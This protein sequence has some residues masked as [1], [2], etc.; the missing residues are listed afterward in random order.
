MDLSNVTV[1]VNDISLVNGDVLLTSITPTFTMTVGGS[2]VNLS[3]SD[4]TITFYPG[5]SASGTPVS[6]KISAVGTYYASVTASGSNTA[7]TN[8]TTFKATATCAIVFSGD[9]SIDKIEDVTVGQAVTMPSAPVVVGKVFTGYYINGNEIGAQYIVNAS[10]AVDGVITIAAIYVSETGQYIDVVASGYYDD[11]EEMK[12][13]LDTLGVSHLGVSDRTAFVVF[14]AYGFTE[15]D[16]LTLELSGLVL[17]SDLSTAATIVKSIQYTAD[18]RYCIKWSDLS[19]DTKCFKDGTMLT[20]K[21]YKTVS[22]GTI[23]GDSTLLDTAYGYY[24]VHYFLNFVDGVVISNTE[25]AT[26]APNIDFLYNGKVVSLPTLPTT[27]KDG[28]TYYFVGWSLEQIGNIIIGAQYTVNSDDADSGTCKIVMYANWTEKN[29]DVYTVS[30]VDSNGNS[31]GSKLVSKGDSVALPL[32]PAVEGKTFAYWYDES[33]SNHTSVATYGYYTPSANITLKAYYDDNDPTTWTLN[34]TSDDITKGTVYATGTVSNG[35]FGTIIAVPGEGYKV[36]TY[37]APTNAVVVPMA[38]NVYL[39]Y[40]TGSEA[41]SVVF[42]FVA[43]PDSVDY[44]ISIR[45]YTDT[46]GQYGFKVKLES[47][48]GGYIAKTNAGTNPSEL[49]IKYVYRQIIP[50]TN[51]WTYY[52]SGV[53]SGV[54]DWTFDITQSVTSYEGAQTIEAGKYLYT[55]YAVFKYYNGSEIEYAISETILAIDIPVSS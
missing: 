30:F 45:N 6:D 48:D 34:A 5:D 4:Y 25:M 39:V 27:T 49:S 32:A 33:D 44:E 20:M 2:S 7:G 40:H 29:A 52:T 19:D 54:V 55:A 43:I 10:D 46:S 8:G 17:R 14:D 28:K 47:N 15:G 1:T 53:S 37:S 9:A 12:S 3:T 13:V 22:S 36:S 31:L 41:V 38:D 23:T 42:T 35:S 21:V 51:F 16:Y 18:G 50:N 26:A 11:D 24:L